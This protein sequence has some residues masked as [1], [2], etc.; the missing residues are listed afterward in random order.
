MKLLLSSLLLLLVSVATSPAQQEAPR[1]SYVP[2]KD[3]PEVPQEIREQLVTWMTNFQNAVH[4][5]R[6][7]EF[8]EA[9]HWRELVQRSTT[10]GGEPLPG[11][12]LQKL[13]KAMEVTCVRMLP[14]LKTFF[15]YDRLE[16]RRIDYK[17]DAATI[18]GRGYDADGLEGKARWWMV[19]HEG[20]W[21]L[22]DYENVSI[23]MGFS[24]I[25][26]QALQAQPGAPMRSKEVAAKFLQLSMAAEDGDSEKAQK[27]VEELLAL[28]LP[29]GIREVILL[30]K[31]GLLG[32]EG[33][34]DGVDEVLAELEK[35]GSTNPAYFLI[36][37]EC[38]QI[39][40]DYQE[41]VVWAR[42]Y[43]SAIGHDLDSWQMLVESHQELGQK[44]ETLQAARD[45]VAD[46]PQSSLAM[47][48][49]WQAL[50]EAERVA[51]IRPLLSALAPAAE[52]FEGFGSAAYLEDDAAALK[53]LIEVMNALK[54]SKEDIEEWESSLEDISEPVAEKPKT[55]DAIKQ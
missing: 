53:L 48:F 31:A 16:I 35:A 12:E 40:E 49:Y 50:P 51:T 3:A 13:T 23:G 18:V 25:M 33:D 28:E 41:C 30:M 38:S 22:V 5:M 39:K 11:A 20:K 27:L 46:Y 6:A 43:G 9:L 14:Y 55:P 24:S 34:S 7:H 45:W 21:K 17:S 37:A 44:T 4:R 2:M 8:Q 10:S 47:H 54:M 36:R 26:A 42:K 29:A 32:E 1:V 19:R 15:M 52:N